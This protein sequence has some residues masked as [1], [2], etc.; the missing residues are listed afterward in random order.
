MMRL[1]VFLCFLFVTSAVW[2]DDAYDDAYDA[3]YTW[4]EDEKLTDA[5]DC[6]NDNN[7]FVD[8]CEA[9][10]NEYSDAYSEAR[11]KHHTDTAD[12]TGTKAAIAG[13]E[14]FID[15]NE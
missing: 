5:R 15:E 12:C 6:G 11:D 10:S 3:G 4:A 1:S 9:W 13:C 7:P 2:A 14:S 8:G